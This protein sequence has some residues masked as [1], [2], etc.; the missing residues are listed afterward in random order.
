MG[1]PDGAAAIGRPQ[2]GI[3]PR[4]FSLE[5]VTREAVIAKYGTFVWA[6]SQPLPRSDSF[7]ARASHPSSRASTLMTRTKEIQL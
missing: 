3:S 4:G 7:R 1:R 2:G 6:C 5:T